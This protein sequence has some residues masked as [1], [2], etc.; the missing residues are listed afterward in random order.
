MQPHFVTRLFV[1]V[2]LVVAAVGDMPAGADASS[3]QGCT[4][5]APGFA[6]GAEPS[7]S[8][9][10]KTI[11]FVRDGAVWSVRVATGELRCL[12]R[13]TRDQSDG[14]PTWDPDGYRIAFTRLVFEPNGSV[15][16]RL[17]IMSAR[18]SKPKAISKHSPRGV[19]SARWSPGTSITFSTTCHI[20]TMSSRGTRVRI[21]RTPGVVCASGPA[22]SYGGRLIAF[23]GKLA[24]APTT[25]SIL[26]VRHSGSK[27]SVLSSGEED[28]DPDWSPNG[29]SIVMSRNCRI[30]LLE[31]RTKRVR[32]LTGPVG[33]VR[34]RT[35]PEW[36]AQGKLIAYAAGQS[37]YVM[38]PDGSEQRRVAGP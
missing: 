38:K 31:R 11:A 15:T 28:I 18:G 2:A 21:L 20:G 6:M 26:S 25:S 27:L 1:L 14:S 5:G 9:D 12:S 10:G 7:W 36:S 30:A 4:M 23:S 16:S 32:F 8:P 3:S 33:I 22:W 17:L 19:R 24:V 13:P 37:V 35:D 29:R 34:C